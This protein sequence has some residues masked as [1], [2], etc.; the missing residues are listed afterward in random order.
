VFGVFSFLIDLAGAIT[1]VAGQPEDSPRRRLIDN[2]DSDEAIGCYPLVDAVEEEDELVVVIEIPGFYS[3]DIRFEV[4]EGIL[5]LADNHDHEFH[6][7]LLPAD[8]NLDE[9]TCVHFNN[10]V[11]I[12]KFPRR[13]IPCS[14]RR[15]A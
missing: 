7:I 10:G 6:E 9:P 13:E 11:I 3:T 2:D 12:I 4:R 14:Q 15:I 5:I 1:V 8:Y